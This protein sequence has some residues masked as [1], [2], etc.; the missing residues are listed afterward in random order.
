MSD[1]EGQAER[2]NHDVVERNTIL[3]ID[4]ITK[5]IEKINPKQKKNILSNIYNKE[6]Y[7][8]YIAESLHEYKTFSV[9]N[10][11]G[12]ICFFDT[13]Y[14]SPFKVIINAHSK[15]VRC[16]IEFDSDRI[17]SASYDKSIKVWDSNTY[18]LLFELKGHTEFIRCLLK[19]D[20]SKFAS[21]ANDHTIKVWDI[22]EQKLIYTIQGST[23]FV[24]NLTQLEQNL[25]ASGTGDGNIILWDL[26]NHIEGPLGVLEG[27]K[28]S[29]WSITKIQSDK[30]KYFASGSGDSSV[31]IWDYSSKKC[32]KI[33]ID[34]TTNIVSLAVM[35]K[36][37][38]AS[39]C[40]DS[41]I[42]FWNFFQGELIKKIQAY[43]DDM[44]VCSSAL[45][46]D[47]YIYTGSS[48]GKIIL[49]DFKDSKSN[50]IAKS[51]ELK[52]PNRSL[53]MLN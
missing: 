40:S 49:W 24:L 3:N 51:Y 43:K 27:H 38:L 17:I 35:N 4:Q 18:N 41:Y 5:I 25:W 23:C 45:F 28:I 10:E 30:G 36:K 46:Q 15:S 52:T 8:H 1:K 42:R 9:G 12:S 32:K 6:C 2:D 50:F 21:G 26:L 20:R 37:I 47:K 34:G 22:D 19:L 31:R 11:D 44:L 14:S 13:N 48:N 7:K 33:M 53:L 29:V 39:F 16:L